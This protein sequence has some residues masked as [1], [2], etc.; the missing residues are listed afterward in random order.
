[1]APTITTTLRWSLRYNGVETAAQA[2]RADRFAVEKN[3]LGEN[4]RSPVEA[5][6]VA[7]GL[8]P[9]QNRG[10]SLAHVGREQLPLAGVDAG[11][12]NGGDDADGPQTGA[13]V[14]RVAK[15]NGGLAVVGEDL[16]MRRQIVDHRT[17]QGRPFPGDEDRPHQHQRGHTREHDDRDQLVLERQAAQQ[18]GASVPKSGRLPFGFTY[19]F[20][21]V[22][23]MYRVR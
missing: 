4:Q 23:P 5:V 11:D 20:H 9:G 19:P 12:R 18:R 15:R 10:G 8:R 2:D 6:A 1:M 17:P 7:Q 3:G 21:P 14:R 13:R 22:C 16:G